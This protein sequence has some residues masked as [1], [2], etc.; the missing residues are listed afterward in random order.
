M[1]GWGKKRQRSAESS[2]VPSESGDP[3][4]TAVLMEGAAFPFEAFQRQVAKAKVCGRR[5]SGVELT[6]DRILTFNAGDELFA[7]ALMPGPYPWS[8]LQG[9]CDT[10]WMWP[11]GSSAQDLARHRTHLLVTMVG[12]SSNRVARRLMATE[13]T[14]WAAG[15]PEVMGVYWP[16][17]TL[18]HYPTIFAEMAK[19]GSMEAPPLYLWVDFRLFR[20]TDGSVGLFTT[21]LNSLGHMEIEIPSIRMKGGKLRDW[22]FNI[23]CYM[24]DNGAVLKDGDTV[25]M[26]ADQRIRI[27]HRASSFGHAGT[28]LCLEA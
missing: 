10:A 17:A 28:V 19:I 5:P 25:G 26:D 15:Q 13:V 20:N 6:K 9:P 27:R 22:A 18:V 11:P 2:Q 16:E 23:V 21:G 8:D 1:L 4:I 7:V 24:L 14:A 3:V 12:G